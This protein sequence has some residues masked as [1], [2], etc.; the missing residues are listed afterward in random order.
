M[1][2]VSNAVIRQTINDEKLSFEGQSYKC[3]EDSSPVFQEMFL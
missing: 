3:I 2:C 1:F